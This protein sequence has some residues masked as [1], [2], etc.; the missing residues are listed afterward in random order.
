MKEKVAGMVLLNSAGGMNNK[1]LKELEPSLGITIFLF[2]LGIIDFLLSIKPISR[3]LFDRLANKETIRSILTDL[4][5]N[6]SA[7]D[8]DLVE[9]FY[10]P[11]QDEGALDVFVEIITG[12]LDRQHQSSRQIN[13]LRR[14]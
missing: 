12:N 1:H 14:R 11:S 10:R 5:S 6:K 2:V 9:I 4:Y 7:V 13:L 3:F 8:D